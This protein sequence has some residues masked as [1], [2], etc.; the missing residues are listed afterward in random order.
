M[1]CTTEP[2][3]DIDGQTISVGRYML[4]KDGID[5][6]MI[7]IIED[8]LT[9]DLVAIVDNLPLEPARYRLD[10]LQPGIQLRRL[11]DDFPRDAADLDL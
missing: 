5:T 7:D 9:F 3:R 6:L 2:I 10:E 11:P 4:V 1:H 8:E